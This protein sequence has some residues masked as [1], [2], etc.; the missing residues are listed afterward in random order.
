MSLCDVRSGALSLDEVFAAVRRPDAGGVALFIGTVR[1]HS[2][3]QAVAALEYSAYESMAKKEMHSIV[4]ELELEIPG[5]RL[6]VVHRVGDLAIGDIAV[7]CAASAAHRGEA[8]EACQKL[9]DRIKQRV[10]IWK[11]EFGSE[12]AHWVGWQDARQR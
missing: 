12:G 3:G 2:A 4:A 9:I 10:P 1:N 5:V 7:I 6:A 11:R 8:F